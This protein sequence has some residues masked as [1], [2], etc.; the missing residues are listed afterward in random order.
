MRENGPRISAGLLIAFGLLFL[1]VGA[2]SATEIPA[3]LAGE[4]TDAGG[5]PLAGVTVRIFIGGRKATSARTDSTGS[6]AIRFPVD[7][8]EEETVVACASAPRSDLVSE[9]AVLR[10]C[11]ADR[12]A[13]VWSPCVPRVGLSRWARWEVR[14]LDAKGVLERLQRD[15]CLGG[16]AAGAHEKGD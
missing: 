6:Y 14:I 15:G 11:R 8:A 4:V 2:Q 10:E 16:A 13:G 1:P 7:P 3:G 5:R 12:E 9:W